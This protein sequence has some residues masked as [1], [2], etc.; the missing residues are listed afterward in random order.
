MNLTFDEITKIIELSF[1]IIG[2]LLVVFGW[3]IPHKQSIKS[4]NQQQEFEKKLL[5]AQWEKELLDNQISKFYGP[6]A[7]LL[8]E[9]DLRTSLIAYQLGRKV[10]FQNEQGKISDLPENE[11]KIWRHFIDTYS[12]PIQARI[13][14]IIQNNQHLIYKSEIPECFKPYMEY[15]LGW[16]LLDNQKRNGV[17]NHYEY[18]YSYN[19][20][21][22]F[23][24]YIERTLTILLKRQEEIM[25]ICS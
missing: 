9:Q 4:A 16:E 20:P 22:N 21:L 6:I 1:A 25:E 7:E 10:I 17:P 23:N 11:Q 14:E 19:Y 8:R 3:I 24:H 13:L 5:C 2:L 18:Y 15:V 12:I